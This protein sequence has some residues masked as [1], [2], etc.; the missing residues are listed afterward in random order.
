[1]RK[2]FLLAGAFV[3]GCVVTVGFFSYQ[4]QMPVATF[5]TQ[6]TPVPTPLM[7][8][9]LDHLRT[10]QFSESPITLG[11][12]I[13]DTANTRSQL[14]SWKFA[15][16]PGD[17]TQKTVTGVINLPK[18]SGTY[19]LLVM[20]RGYIPPDAYKPGAGTQ[21]SASVFAS[22]GYI[23]IAPD[24]LGF[25]G[26]D[27]RSEDA[28]EARFQTYTTTLSLISSLSTLNTVLDASYS[29]QIKVDP[30]RIGL[31]G[32]S[33]GGHIA[34][35]T[36]AITGAKYPTVLW[37][38]VSKSFPFSVLAFSD[39]DD[40][41]GKAQRADLARFESRY[42]T[43]LFDPAAYYDRIGAPLQIHQGTVDTAVPFWWSDELVKNLKAD[44]ISVEYHVY[45]G[46][47]HN[48]RPAWNEVVNNSLDFY[49]KQFSK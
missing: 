25:G 22:Q 45:P 42:D 7:V 38:P 14:F 46:S 44:K 21:P 24:F 5:L 16:R 35:A 47:D 41:R 20:L 6:P 3:F 49:T 13:K 9:S 33:N 30:T 37:A 34:L 39:E 15:P 48:L 8:Y 10:T 26:S 17:S 1:M 2:Y 43:A 31:W 4:K 18:T 36:L 11:A 32:H 29:G 12:L 19:P 28:Y 40:D 23:T 27:A